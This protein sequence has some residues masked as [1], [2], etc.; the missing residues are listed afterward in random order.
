MSSI[1][2]VMVILLSYLNENREEREEKIV[3]EWFQLK[4]IGDILLKE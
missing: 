2:F 1:V 3:A 4:I